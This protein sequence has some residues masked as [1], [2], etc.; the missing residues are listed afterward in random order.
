MTIPPAVLDHQ[1]TAGAPVPQEPDRTRPLRWYV[2]LAVLLA[3]S[4]GLTALSYLMPTFGGHHPIYARDGEIGNWFNVDEEANLATWWGTMLLGGGGLL[5]LLGAWIAR[6]TRARG[7]FAWVLLGLLLLV[8]SLDEASQMHENLA[9]FGQVVDSPFANEYGWLIIGIPAAVVVVGI[10]AFSGL[11]L[12]LRSLVVLTIGFVLFFAGAVGVEAV[13]SEGADT[14]EPL[15][16]MSY[17]LEEIL[18]MAGAS[19]LAVAP[20]A[21]VRVATDAGGVR[22]QL[23]PRLGGHRAVRRHRRLR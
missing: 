5:Y 4:L 15:A 14:I 13:Q 22:W 2:P 3:T 23:G 8:M 17:H 7:T 1:P 11:R 18:E 6:A 10:A 12:P 19:L 20:L 21:G 16:T 9:R